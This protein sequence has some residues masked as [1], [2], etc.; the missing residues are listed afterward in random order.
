M[1]DK[2]IKKRLEERKKE[3]EKVEGNLR[4][5]GKMERDLNTRKG[6]LIRNSL[7][8][9]GKISELESQLVKKKNEQ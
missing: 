7:I 1:E 6:N 9:N 4:E 3:L 2:E 8:L 5:L